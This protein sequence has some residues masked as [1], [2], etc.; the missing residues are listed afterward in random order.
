M[1]KNIDRKAFAIDYKELGLDATWGDADSIINR[2]TD[3][4]LEDFI[5]TH[6]A[7]QEWTGLDMR[8]EFMLS[9]A[10]STRALRQNKDHI[11]PSART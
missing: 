1:T 11:P 2:L 8:Q 10:V 4:E 3:N 9:L 6:R 5:N 7:V